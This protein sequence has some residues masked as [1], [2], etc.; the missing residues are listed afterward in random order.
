MV[1]HQTAS[2][3]IPL[4]LSGALHL[5]A[6]GGAFV[7]G[8]GLEPPPRVPVELVIEEPPPA[9]LPSAPQPAIP[10]RTRPGPQPVKVQK[11]IESPRAE[12]P[13]PEPRPIASATAGA[14]MRVP[15]MADVGTTPSD[16]A[17]TPDPP[18]IDVP[19]PRTPAPVTTGRGP[20]DSPAM[21]E[22]SRGPSGLSSAPPV[23]AAASGGAALPGA[24]GRGRGDLRGDPAVASLPRGPTPGNEITRAARLRG[25]YQVLPSYPASARRARAE[26]TTLLRLLVLADG[27]VGEVMIEKSA[28]HPDVDRAAA[29]AVRHWRFEPARRRTETVPSWVE[30]PVEFRLR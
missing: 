13:A 14:D 18:R 7:A 9:A 26:G 5:G 25:G 30:Q 23:E 27:R 19:S 16:R 1:R 12:V 10:P 15:T 3:S 4:L 11:S 21:A 6:G 17:G 8:F 28:G 22:V 29:D 2:L 20:S 24:P